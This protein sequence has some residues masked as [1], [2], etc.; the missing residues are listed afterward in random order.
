MTHLCYF[1]TRCSSIFNSLIN[2]SFFSTW[3]SRVAGYSIL[4]IS[5]ILCQNVTRS[6][7]DSLIFS[8]GK[9]KS[10]LL[11][12]LS[13]ILDLEEVLP[14]Y[15][16]V[17][18]FSHIT[19][20]GTQH[21][22]I[23]STLMWIFNVFWLLQLTDSMNIKIYSGFSYISEVKKN[24]FVTVTA[25]IFGISFFFFWLWDLSSP[26]I[27]PA[28]ETWSPNHWI[29]KGFSTGYFLK[30]EWMIHIYIKNSHIYYN[31]YTILFYWFW[32]STGSLPVV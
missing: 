4:S 3:Y 2:P 21:I 5:Y 10:C 14:K 18:F 30:E 13:T 31:S 12:I 17:I 6:H 19:E 8:M 24:F 15:F 11:R 7:Q 26:P 32:F 28:M 20:E 29:A 1:W 23:F 25:F 27:H 9:W 22:T 16:L